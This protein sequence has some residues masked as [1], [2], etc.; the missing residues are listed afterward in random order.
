MHSANST[1]ATRIRTGFILM[2]LFIT[3]SC[4][5]QENSPLSRYGMGDLVPNKNIINRGMG[6]I[7][8]GYAD[9]Q[10]IN[11]AN[12]A[13]LSNLTS[14]VFDVGAG[15][16]IRNL[17]SNTSP[18]R[19]NSTNL[20]ISY[21]QLGFPLASGKTNRKL[22]AKDIYWGGS[23]GLRPVSRINY[24][25]ADAGRVNNIDS[26]QDL[27]EGSGGL[28]QVNL[29]TGLQVKNFSIGFSTGYSFGNKD[30]SSRRT[31]LND[32]LPY[33][34][35]NIEQFSNFGG[36]FLQ[37]GI[38]YKIKTKNDGLI[39]LGAVANWQQKLSGGRDAL[40]ETFIFDINDNPQ[41]VDTV[42]YTQDAKGTVIM[43]GSYNF[44]FTFQNK[45]WLV[46]ADL[47]T[48]Q[49]DN[50]S[51]FGTKD[52]AVQNSWMARAGAQYYPAKLNTPG[53]KYWSFVNYRFGAFYGN[54]Y[55]KIGENRKEYGVSFGAGLPLTTFQRLQRGEFVTLNT[56]V[57]VGSR[58][59]RNNVGFRE[60]VVRFSFG[61]T[62]NARWFQKY[63]Y[64]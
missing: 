23:F 18:D 28:S 26:V 1:M 54:D 10:S 36:L 38:Q 19:Y 47:E 43:P 63:K 12:P 45:N 48:Q 7:S 57:E 30:F 6:G 29:S 64:Q 31:I 46:G 42:Q 11:L 62:M 3:A 32:S 37:T 52:P 20:N 50:Y 58:G 35:S 15:V 51:F 49:W 53:T 14:T 4:V 27:Y 17:R 8:A 60:N 16:D 55:I 24:K 25:I 39:R 13:A 21:L 59:N 56:A 34:R 41:T 9:Y 2:A 5:A 44:G 40:A 61:L 22:A 33:F